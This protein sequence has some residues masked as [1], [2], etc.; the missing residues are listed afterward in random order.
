MGITTKKL[1]VDNCL[2][3]NNSNLEDFLKDRKIFPDFIFVDADAFLVNGT[4][5]NVGEDIILE[6]IKMRFK[7]KLVFF[8]R[9][10]IISFI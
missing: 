7:K 8:L 1:I 10:K 4:P 5:Y 2:I 6:I 3:K 9:V